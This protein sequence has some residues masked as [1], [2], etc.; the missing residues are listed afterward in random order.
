[1]CVVFPMTFHALNK[2]EQELRDVKLA[3]LDQPIERL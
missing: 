3:K 1:M 2:H